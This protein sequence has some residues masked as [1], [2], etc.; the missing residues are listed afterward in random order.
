VTQL[1]ILIKSCQ[2]PLIPTPTGQVKI[3]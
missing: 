2:T 3:M 1:M